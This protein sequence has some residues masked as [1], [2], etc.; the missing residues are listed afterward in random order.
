M[1]TL[2]PRQIIDVLRKLQT[3]DDEIRHVREKRDGMVENLEKLQ[4]P[5]ESSWTT[6]TAVPS[7]ASKTFL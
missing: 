7:R 2:N 5:Q 6:T 3:I 4:P 1:A